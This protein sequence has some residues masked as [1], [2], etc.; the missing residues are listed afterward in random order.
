MNDRGYLI[1]RPGLVDPIGRGPIE[2][3]HITHKEPLVANDMLNHKD[4]VQ[5]SLCN[6]FTD[7]TIQRFYEVGT[8]VAASPMNICF[9][10]SPAF[11]CF[12]VRL[13]RLDLYIESCL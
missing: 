5:K 6:S 7:R 11:Y 10:P 8:Q 1:A 13:L 12:R 3:Q 2:Q 9:R 4:F